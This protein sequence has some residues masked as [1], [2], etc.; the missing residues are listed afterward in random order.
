MSFCLLRLLTNDPSQIDEWRK[1]VIPNLPDT[2][3]N[4]GESSSEW[5]NKYSAHFLFS[6]APSVSWKEVSELLRQWDECG[7]KEN[8]VECKTYLTFLRNTEY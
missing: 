6:I 1:L 2:I 4:I 8:E 7:V 3:I 5:D